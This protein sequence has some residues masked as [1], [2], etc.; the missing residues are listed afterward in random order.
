MGGVT[1]CVHL[2]SDVV[3]VAR[4]R[5][6]SEEQ[7]GA[8]LSSVRSRLDIGTLLRSA[9]SWTPRWSC[10]LPWALGLAKRGPGLAVGLVSPWCDV[11]V[12][13]CGPILEDAV[14]LSPQEAGFYGPFDG[15]SR[16]GAAWLPEDRQLSSGHASSEVPEGAL[17][18][19]CKGDWIT[20]WR[21]RPTASVAL[22][23]QLRGPLGQV[24]PP[25]TCLTPLLHL[26]KPHLL[27][28]SRDGDLFLLPTPVRSRQYCRRMSWDSWL[29]LSSL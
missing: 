21:T 26:S 23:C 5:C 16:P 2:S 11:A 18:A 10:D 15:T 25:L 8:S 6:S 7:G 1:A 19:S 24:P 20:V 14:P 13:D 27:L 4:S 28:G 29:D 17:L 12:L 22:R 3:L 9:P